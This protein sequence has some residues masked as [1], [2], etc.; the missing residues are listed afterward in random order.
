MTNKNINELNELKEAVKINIEWV[1]DNFKEGRRSV[2]YERIHR[3]K[4]LVKMIE[5]IID[6][7]G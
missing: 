3:V 6:I 2:A 5:D 1:V 7:I 4:E